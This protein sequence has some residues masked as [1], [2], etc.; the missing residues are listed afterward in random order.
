MKTPVDMVTARGHKVWFNKPHL[1]PVDPLDIRTHTIN[2]CRYN[3]ALNWHLIKHLAL[4]V[5]LAYAYK[6]EWPEVNIPLQAGYA[7]AHD[8]HEIIVGDM[9]SGLKKYVPEYRKIEADWEEHFHNS[10]DLPLEHKHNKFVTT[11]DRRALVVEMAMLSH[12]A[13]DL[14]QQTMGGP[15]S[16]AERKAMANI[17]KISLE[18]CWQIVWTAVEKARAELLKNEQSGDFH[19]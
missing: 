12:P 8:F 18:S 7:A 15:I 4:C 2:M 9:V 19:G 10:I 17:M 6:P 5:D 11:I 13:A 1:T 16:Q 14:V 3:G